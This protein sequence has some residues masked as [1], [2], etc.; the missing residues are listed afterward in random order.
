MTKLNQDHDG[1][2]VVLRASKSQP[3][4][5]A[6]IEPKPALSALCTNDLG[7]RWT[8]A[9]RRGN[10][11]AAWTISDEVLRRRVESRQ[12]CGDWP[13]HLQYIWRGDTLRNKRV[14]VRCYHGLG[15]T[16]QFIRFAAPLRNLVRHAIFWVQPELLELARA[17]RGVDQAIPLHDGTPDVAYDLD[18][19]IMELP[20]ALR[21]TPEILAGGVPYLF[22]GD[23]GGTASRKRVGLVWRSGK[24]NPSRSI[25][26]ELLTRV[27]EVAGLELVSLQLDAEPAELAAV[28]AA[29][30]RSANIHQ[31]AMRVMMLDLVI[32]VDTMA[33]HL[34][35]ALGRPVWTLLPVDCDW[36][37]MEG[38][39]DSPWYPSMRLFRQRQAGRWREVLDDVIA[40]LTLGR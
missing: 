27:R 18:I 5:P 13:R 32:T 37:W 23:V 3:Q 26:V 25:P 14:L 10:F 7:A 31:L 2:I 12:G 24:W 17:A 30:W 16:I 33:A 22:A 38:R 20:H 39:S 11:M 19:E 28:G 21:I 6:A 4:K 35:G 36:R 1:S 34:A 15:D 29:D 9:M 8:S 40:E